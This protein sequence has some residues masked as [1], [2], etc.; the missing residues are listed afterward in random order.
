M[1]RIISIIIALFCM[2]GFRFLPVFPGMTQSAMQVLG[3]FAGALILWMTISIDWPSMLCLASLVLVPEL[4]MGSV[5]S[6]SLGNSTVAFLLF[7]F[8]CTYAISTTSFVKR[9]AIM[10]ISSRL[11]RKSPWHFLILYC[12]SVLIIGLVMS[13]SVVFVIYLPILKAICDELNLTKEDK[14]ANAL[15]LGQL[16]CCAISCG[17][18]PIAHVFSVMAMGFYQTATGKTVSYASYMGFAIPVGIICFVIMLLLFRFVL[19]PD[20][21]SLKGL[22]IDAL[23]DSVEKADKKENMIL[24]VFFAVVA[25]WVLPE[26]MGSLLPGIS[27]FIKAQ[28]TA[29]PPLVGAVALCLITIDGKPLMGFKDTMQ[30]GVEWGSVMMAGATLA[31]GTAMTNGDIGLTAWLSASISPMLTNISPLSLVAVFAIWAACMTNVASNMVSVT[32]V[33]A[34]A[35]PLCA[36]TGGAVSTPAVAMIIGMLCGYA[37]ATPPAHPNVPLAIGSGW[38]KAS[39]VITYGSIMMVVSIIVSVV[40]GYPIASYLMGV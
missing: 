26:F 29:F 11:A 37:F 8:M 25:M 17:M 12:A 1:K 16:F 32:V 35:I 33:C 36:A 39:Q 10:F 15:I 3:I 4:T 2:L 13:P 19:R 24:L 22:N 28:G 6:S 14:L 30:K 21:S 7:T 9:C 5:L 23:K 38:T 40:V 34:V 20:M 31:L 27:G 18:T